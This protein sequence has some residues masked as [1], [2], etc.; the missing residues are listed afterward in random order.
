MYLCP[1]C[2]QALVLNNKQY[3]CV[4][5]HSFD[6]AKEGYVNLLPVQQKNSQDP[7]DNKEMMQAR[8]AFLQADWYRPMAEQVGATL[9]P[10]QAAKLLDLGCGEGYYSNLLQQQ[11]TLEEQHGIDISKSA[12]RSAAKQYTQVHFAVA[13][14]YS[15]PFAAG[16]FDAIV[17][18][19]APSLASE[20]SRVLKVGGHL[21]TVTPAPEHLLQL[22]QAIYSEVRLHND[23]ITDITDFQHVTRERLSFQLM[24]LTATDLM[25][26]ITMVPLGW[27]FSAAVKAELLAQAPAIQCDFYLD[28]YQK[29]AKA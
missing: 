29:V 28:L 4:N 16:Y 3:Q 20:L 10:L 12:I 6:Q 5:R 26:L 22:K 7:G 9:K 27:K 25:Q 2:Q 13:S 19:Y 23:A 14:A 15:L 21:L 1:L 8:R 24:Q 11:L 18:I 17:R